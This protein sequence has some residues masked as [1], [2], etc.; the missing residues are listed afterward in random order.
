M[1]RIVL[2]TGTASGLGTCLVET[3][4]KSGWDVLRGDRVC[5]NETRQHF[6]LDVTRPEQIAGKFKAIEKLDV[7]INNAGVT[8]DELLVKATLENWQKIMDVNLKGTALCSR[9]A[10][11]LMKAARG[12]QIINVG[13]WSGLAGAAG[14]SIYSAAK[15]GL[16]GL[17]KALAHEGSRY[18]IRANII[19]PGVLPTRM[20]DGISLDPFRSANVLGR[21]NDLQEVADFFFH[22]AGMQNVSGQVFQ[23]DSRLASWT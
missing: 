5:H 2:I 13:S 18:N 10:F 14:Q 9:A 17:T 1:G 11:P 7:L 12:G 16:I 22:L 15:A 3:F 21:I 6:Q 4:S 19:L 23:L 20:T 8:E